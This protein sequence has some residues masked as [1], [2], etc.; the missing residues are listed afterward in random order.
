MLSSVAILAQ[1]G[2]FVRLGQYLRRSFGPNKLC[3]VRSRTLLSI[4]LLF[5]SAV[6][7]GILAGSSWNYYSGPDPLIIDIGEHT[8]SARTVFRPTGR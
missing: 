7:I 5:N 6:A 2:R 4:F 3:F 1:V 8:H